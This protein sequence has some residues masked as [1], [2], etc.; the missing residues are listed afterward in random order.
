LFG[1]TFVDH[2]VAS[3]MA[4]ANACNRFVSAQE[5]RRYMRHV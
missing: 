5:R 3:R 1:S 4:E 2:Y